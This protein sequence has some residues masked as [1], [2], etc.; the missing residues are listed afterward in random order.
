MGTV[1]EASAYGLLFQDLMMASDC[2]CKLADGHA[3]VSWRLTKLCLGQSYRG[4]HTA[5]AL[6]PHAVPDHQRHV[7]PRGQGPLHHPCAAG[8]G[9]SGSCATCIQGEQGGEQGYSPV[10]AAANSVVLLLLCT[11]QRCRQ[12]C[13]CVGRLQTSCCAA[14]VC[15]GLPQ[16]CWDA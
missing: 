11:A 7:L 13:H 5:A 8:C 6:L 14:L 9:C 4:A 15:C 2:L 12:C 3:T 10:P 1:V 16:Y